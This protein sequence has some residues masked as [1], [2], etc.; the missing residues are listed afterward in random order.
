M[1]LNGPIRR[2]EE[3]EQQKEEEEGEIPDVDPQSHAIETAFNSSSPA[4]LRS[5]P[6]DRCTKLKLKRSILV[7]E[8]AV[9]ESEESGLDSDY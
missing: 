5:C 1:S 7:D 2:E 9:E 6:H 8:A 3:E 4:R